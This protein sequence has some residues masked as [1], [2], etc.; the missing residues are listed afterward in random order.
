MAPSASPAY[1]ANGRP[2]PR[3]AGFWRRRYVAVGNAVT[4]DSLKRLQEI[5]SK[6]DEH[7][8]VEFGHDAGGGLVLT[9]IT[10]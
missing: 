6:E 9:F 5:A 8:R 4:E 7:I 2:S 10:R 1:A 3:S